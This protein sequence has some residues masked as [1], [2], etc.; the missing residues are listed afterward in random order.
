MRGQKPAAGSASVFQFSDPHSGAL[1]FTVDPV[2][3]PIFRSLNRIFALA[4]RQKA[5][6]G[7]FWVDRRDRTWSDKSGNFFERGAAES[8][9]PLPSH[10]TDR[11]EEIFR[12][13]ASSRNPKRRTSG[14]NAWCF[15]KKTRYP[16][17]GIHRY[18]ISDAPKERLWKNAQS[19]P[20]FPNYRA[21]R[22]K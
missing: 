3:A 12:W 5:R 16:Q 10:R 21:R 20:P 22:Y 6:P 17:T 8:A 19:P 18:Q 13:P 9:R 7:G 2:F 11:G 4:R 1:R 14:K 15:P